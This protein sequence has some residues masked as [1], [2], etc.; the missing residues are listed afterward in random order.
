MSRSARNGLTRIEVL[1][2]MASVVVLIGLF[3]PATRRVRGPANRILCTNNLKQLMMALD[4]YESTGGPSLYL[5]TSDLNVPARPRFPPGC[6]GPGAAPEERHSWM[7]ALLPHLEQQRVYQQFDLTKGYTENLSPAQTR[8]KTLLCPSSKG[9]ATSDA[10]THYVAMSG[11]GHDAAK[12]PAGAV[13]NGFMGYERLTS[14]AMIEDGTANTIALMETRVN[15]GPWARGGSATLRGFDPATM[16]LTGADQPF[17]GWHSG[18][19]PVAYADGSVR[20]LPYS[21]DP[22]ILA[23][24]ITIAGGELLPQD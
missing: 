15:P 11:I 23:S 13:G 2:I 5:S 1:V 8:F 6:F 21:T 22:K 24:L 19:M 14:T 12:Q 10:V 7:V 9:E 20:N 3:L 4:S 18:A 16:S 17:G